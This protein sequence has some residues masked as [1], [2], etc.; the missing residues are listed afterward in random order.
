MFCLAGS[1]ELLCV[2]RVGGQ[3]VIRCHCEYHR[4]GESSYTYTN[5]SYHMTSNDFSLQVC[6]VMGLYVGQLGLKS[7]VSV[8]MPTV[9]RYVYSLSVLAA[10]TV[11]LRVVWVVD[12]IL[13]AKRELKASHEEQDEEGD[14]GD[15]NSIGGGSKD[16]IGDD[17]YDEPPQ[18]SDRS[19]MVYFTIQVSPAISFVC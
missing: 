6:S 9:Q 10:L 16:Q 11:C 13:L 5:T 1:L 2:D 19:F 3:G 12:V 17:D 18:M 14:T 4:N 15:D 7:T 8:D